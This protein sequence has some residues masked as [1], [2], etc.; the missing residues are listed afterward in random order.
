MAWSSVPFRSQKV[1]FVST[2]S[3]STWWKTGECVAS[4][5]SLRCTLPGMTMRTGGVCFSMV[6]ICT[7]EVCVRSSRRSRAGLRSCPA[8]NSVS[9]VSRA[10]WFGGKF[11]DSKL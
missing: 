6:R 1:M 10:G 8:M 4:S 3:P 9:C 11:S 2:A 5:G 7:G